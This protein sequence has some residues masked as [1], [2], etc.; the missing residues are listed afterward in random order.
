M[1]VA[2]DTNVIVRLIV[3]D[4]TTQVD[5]VEHLLDAADEAFIPIITLCEVVWVLRRAYK[6]PAATVATALRSIA[7]IQSVTIDRQAFE[8]GLEMLDAGGDFADG[9][10]LFEAKR[11]KCDRLAT[12]DK[13][14]AALSS[15]FAS[16]P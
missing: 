12:F 1:K 13:T 5:Q 16:P 10:V 15:G 7:G 2:L 6:M 14:F 8:A 11:A 4:D 3:D 9:C